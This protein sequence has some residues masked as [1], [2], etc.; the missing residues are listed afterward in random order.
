YSKYV[1]SSVNKFDVSFSKWQILVNNTDVTTSA[2]SKLSFV[3]VIEKNNH[4]APG[5][6]APS[7]KGYFDIAIDPSNV[8]VS[9]KYTINFSIDNKDV[10]DLMITKYAIVPKTY[11]DGDVLDIITLNEPSLTGT[12]L[13]DISTPGFKF[14][15]FT[16][17]LFFEWHEGAGEVMTDEADTNI[18]NS[19]ATTGKKFT[20]NADLSFEQIIN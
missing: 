8:E 5:T 11:V 3:P 20:I 1:S 17:R 19:A 10:P 9:F 13:F 12:K 7:S 15:P 16:V 6:V 14:E 18:G 4:V 2:N